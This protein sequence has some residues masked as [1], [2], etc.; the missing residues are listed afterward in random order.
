MV[1]CRL[2]RTDLKE[3]L[4]LPV[5]VY[6][7]TSGCTCVCHGPSTQRDQIYCTAVHVVYRT[8]LLTGT[9]VTVSIFDT[10]FSVL[11]IQ[12]RTQPNLVYLLC[13]LIKWR[14]RNQLKTNPAPRQRV[15]MPAR[16]TGLRDRDRGTDCGM[17]MVRR[18]LEPFRT[19]SI[20]CRKHTVLRWHL[21]M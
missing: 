3:W 18:I 21:I 17:Y 7:L 6:S 12:F 4:E 2:D 8:T 9:S 20:A 15:G 13:K 11:F 10:R 19:V 5:D 16:L 14:Q 1:N